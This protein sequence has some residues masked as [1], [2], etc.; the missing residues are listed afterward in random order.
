VLWSVFHCSTHEILLHANLS[1]IYLCIFTHHTPY[2]Y[3]THT[4]LRKVIE[5]RAAILALTSQAAEN[6]AELMKAKARQLQIT[7]ALDLQDE[8][9]AALATK[10]KHELKEYNEQSKRYIQSFLLAFDRGDMDKLP[11][12][13]F[14]PSLEYLEQA[15]AKRKASLIEKVQGK[16]N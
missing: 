4:V 8:Q 7:K 1:L 16:L 12:H 6:E 2:T 10:A 3:R 13:P 5:D 15:I 11:H 9:I 14:M